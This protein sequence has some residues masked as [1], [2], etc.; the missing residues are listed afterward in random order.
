MFLLLSQSVEDGRVQLD[1]QGCMKLARPGGLGESLGWEGGHNFERA[2]R[3]LRERRLKLWALG[4]GTSMWLR[5]WLRL[6]LASPH[7]NQARVPDVGERRWKMMA[8]WLVMVMCHKGLRCNGKRSEGKGLS[9]EGRA[10]L[11]CSQLSKKQI[12]VFLISGVSIVVHSFHILLTH[13]P[14]LDCT[15]TMGCRG[16][17]TS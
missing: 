9:I 1:N 3:E 10:C 16:E 4:F 6:L 11:Q 7:L 14:S 15:D 17:Q 8:L 12:A 5:L 13:C 2:E